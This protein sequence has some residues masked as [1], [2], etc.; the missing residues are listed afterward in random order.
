M[1][2]QKATGNIYIYSYERSNRRM[3]VLTHA[4][5]KSISLM[6][7]FVEGLNYFVL[8]STR[9][10]ISRSLIERFDETVDEVDG[11]LIL[12]HGARRCGRRGRCG[13]RRRER[14]CV[15]R[16]ER[17]RKVGRPDAVYAQP[18]QRLEER[19]AVLCK[20]HRLRKSDT[21]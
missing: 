18:Q 20:L 13:R 6:F 2:Q 1:Q 12:A 17:A 8:F 19:H 9:C 11:E 7:C 15:A 10:F 14:D 5:R 21:R 16:A 3:K 4:G